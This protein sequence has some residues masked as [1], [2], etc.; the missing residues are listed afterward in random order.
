MGWFLHSKFV[1][2][3]CV[4]VVA[5]LAG[6]ATFFY[7]WS[8]SRHWPSPTIATGVIKG[9]AMTSHALFSF[10]SI[11]TW[12]SIRIS[13]RSI[14]FGTWASF[15]FASL[16]FDSWWFGLMVARKGFDTVGASAP[17]RK[18]VTIAFC[19][20]SGFY[21]VYRL[22]VLL[23]VFHFD[24]RYNEGLA[25]TMGT[26]TAG[27][28]QPQVIQIA[29]PP[30]SCPPPHQLPQH[31]SPYMFSPPT[32]ATFHSL[33]KKLSIRRSRSERQF[34][35]LEQ[36]EEEALRRN[37]ESEPIGTKVAALVRQASRRW[38][39]RS[40]GGGR[41]NDV[42]LIHVSLHEEDVEA[43]RGRGRK[44]GSFDEDDED[45]GSV[46]FD[47]TSIGGAAS[48][49]GSYDM[50]NTS[51]ESVPGR[52]LDKGKGRAVSSESE[53]EDSEDEAQ[54]AYEER[55]RQRRNR[56]PV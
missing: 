14:M 26:A 45:D 13:S 53:E 43:R 48:S 9:F 22:L 40:G 20:F 27:P 3:L 35:R 51:H 28:A 55:R 16:V 30:P 33:A 6:F 29:G 5:L 4:L 49:L 12:H 41:Q 1:T 2:H 11:L 56:S 46:L 23:F 38:W 52:K 34:A 39:T 7:A 47:A 37:G 36:R 32:V 54:R 21:A 17:N 18:G 25:A 10:T 50:V 24:V 31:P 44:D 19:V 15:A 8:F 42:P